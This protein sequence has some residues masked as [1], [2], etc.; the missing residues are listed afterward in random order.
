MKREEVFSLTDGEGITT[1]L[2]RV[3][4]EPSGALRVE[5]EEWVEESQV[6]HLTGEPAVV[7]AVGLLSEDEAELLRSWVD[8]MVR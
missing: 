4:K 1:G 7:T 8:E 6:Y 5:V 3:R 2:L